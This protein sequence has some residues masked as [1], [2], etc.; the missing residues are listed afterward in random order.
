MLQ[1]SKKHGRVLAVAAMVLGVTGTPGLAYAISWKSYNTHIDPTTILQKRYPS[2]SSDDYAMPARAY[3]KGTIGS[4]VTQCLAS[5]NQYNVYLWRDRTGLPDDK[6][7]S[8][9]QHGFCADPTADS[10]DWSS[11]KFHFNAGTA[12]AGPK[13]GDGYAE[14]VW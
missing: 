6:E 5:T 7:F 9:E 14:T 2:S 10:A 1:F 11:G 12:N 8:I 3:P 13:A 4:D